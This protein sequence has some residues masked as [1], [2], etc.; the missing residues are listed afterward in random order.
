MG[1]LNNRKLINHS[2]QRVLKILTTLSINNWFN[3]VWKKL[4]SLIKLNQLDI[5]NL[6]MLTT[7]NLRHYIWINQFYTI[8]WRSKIW[9]SPTESFEF[10]NIVNAEKFVTDPQKLTKLQKREVVQ[11]R[12]YVQLRSIYSR[13]LQKGCYIV[14]GSEVIFSSTP[15]RGGGA[16]NNV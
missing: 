13:N 3:K 12:V 16:R 11:E 10:S 15:H 4:S 2:V 1:G 9:T 6:H 7:F 5:E 8:S 14:G